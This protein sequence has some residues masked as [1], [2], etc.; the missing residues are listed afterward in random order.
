MKSPLQHLPRQPGLPSA[1]SKDLR[2]FTAT[3]SNLFHRDRGLSSL[4]QVYKK[5]VF[6]N[7][8][9]TW[10]LQGHHTADKNVW[11]WPLFPSCLSRSQENPENKLL[12]FHHPV[13]HLG[14]KGQIKRGGRRRRVGP[15][16]FVGWNSKISQPH[17]SNETIHSE[18]EVLTQIT[19]LV[20]ASQE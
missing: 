6:K 14:R 3:C 15:R 18:K 10:D 4:Y 20:H 12:G 5:E 11:Q 19:G 1:T 9:L 13:F 16:C 7:A 2:T 8:R 17:V